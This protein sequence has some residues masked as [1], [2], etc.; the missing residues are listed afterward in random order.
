MLI[1]ADKSLVNVAD[2]NRFTPI[3]QAVWV[4]R[5]DMIEL[6]VRSGAL[7]NTRTMVNETTLHFAAAR[8]N[9]EIIKFL[10][11]EGK[12]DCTARNNYGSNALGK[13]CAK[14]FEDMTNKLECVKFLLPHTYA[15]DPKGCYRIE[16]IFEPAV[17]N[18]YTPRRKPE[19][20][21]MDE[22]T[23]YF[24]E[25][26]YCQKYN[27][28]HRL[29]ENLNGQMW[30]LCLFFHDDIER[31]ND[32][33]FPG[34]RNILT[35]SKELSTII[36]SYLMVNLNFE[37]VS[38]EF[39]CDVIA[40][41]FGIGLRQYIEKDL[42]SN[43]LIELYVM[44]PHPNIAIL[45]KKL[46]E[47]NERVDFNAIYDRLVRRLTLTKAMDKLQSIDPLILPF[48]TVADVETTFGVTVGQKK[49]TV[50]SLKFLCRKV[51]RFCI[52]RQN[53]DSVND[54]CNAIMLADLPISLR[55]YLRFIERNYDF[56]SKFYI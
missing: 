50:H 6:L 29:I 32:F 3:M 15:A 42:F 44:K 24:V 10:V 37:E 56:W 43:L 52:L 22:V 14:Y 2:Y 16:D 19:M 7:T 26:F 5:L 20:D 11:I 21:M 13:L 34:L 41:V 12:C 9:L 51:I 55:L 40:E 18:I 49:S 53:R 54:F 35:Y 23:S 47:L 25:N 45:S 36:Y 30:K 38:I 39:V 48:C 46:I 17:L 27:S 33:L 4:D 8:G 1:E 28:K 31:I